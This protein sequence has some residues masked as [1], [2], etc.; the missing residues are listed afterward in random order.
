MGI[1]MRCVSIDGRCV[2][3]CVV[4]C[5][6]TTSPLC[7][8]RVDPK[9]DGRMWITDD[10]IRRKITRINQSTRLSL[11]Q[12]IPPCPSTSPPS[13]PSSPNP[14]HHPASPPSSTPSHSPHPPLTPRLCPSQKSTSTQMRRT[15][16]TTPSASRSVSSLAHLALA[17]P[18]TSARMARRERGDWRV[19]TSTTHRPLPQ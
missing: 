17:R 2:G 3:R 19:S 8:S 12:S 16:P 15:T 4:G 1:V 18:P 9:R 13:P 10:V 14:S 7:I 6:C 5:R 11:P